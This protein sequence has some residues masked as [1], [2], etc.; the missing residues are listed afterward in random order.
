MKFFDGGYVP[1]L[2][3][4]VVYGLMLIWHTGSVALNERTQETVISIQ[5]FTAELTGRGVPRVPGTAVFLTRTRYG[6]P[7]VLKW[8]LRQSRALHARVFVLNVS[9]EMVPYVPAGERLRFEQI[10]PGFWRGVARFGFMQRPDIPALL[11]QAHDHGC[12]ITTDDLTYFVG[13]ETVVARDDG[14]GL[15]RWVEAIYAFMQRNSAHV[16]DYFKLPIEN[17]VEVGREIAI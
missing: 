13:H 15:P 8:H 16:T 10:V 9:T 11:Q 7:P 6:A 12:A 5:D 2:L 4:A 17:V 14:R 1:V 3:A